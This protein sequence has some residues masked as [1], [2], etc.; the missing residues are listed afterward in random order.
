MNRLVGFTLIVLVLMLSIGSLRAESI[1]SFGGNPYV[2]L[3]SI[4]NQ[5]NLK[6]NHSMSFMSGASSNGRGF[7]QSMYTNHLLYQFS[8]KLD[9]QLDLNFVNFGTA[10]FNDKLSI[11][12]NDYNKSTVIPE[13]SLNYR[14]SENFNIIFEMRSVGPFEHNY[15]RYR[16]GR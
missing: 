11:K 15:D 6:M 7:Y 5:N 2:N 13:F 14:P 3:N 4:L 10:N 9:L 8:P 1:G 12:G 16:L